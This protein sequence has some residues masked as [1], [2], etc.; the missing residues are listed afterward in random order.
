MDTG[1]PITDI[2]EIIALYSNGLIGFKESRIMLASVM[3]VFAGVRDEELEKD[4]E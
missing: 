2:Y 4:N 1:Q 3:P